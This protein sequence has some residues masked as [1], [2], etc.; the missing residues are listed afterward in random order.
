MEIGSSLYVWGVPSPDG[1]HLAIH[2]STLN[3]NMWMA[4][5]F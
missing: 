3:S 1:R 2:T 4:E 5:N